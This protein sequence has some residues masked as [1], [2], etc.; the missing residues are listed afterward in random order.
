MFFAK[1]CYFYSPQSSSVI[2][3]DEGYNNTNI[4]KQLSPAKIRLHWLFVDEI[5]LS[6]HSN[7]TSTEELAHG[8]IYF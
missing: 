6:D 2:I 8:I 1:G 4:N 5:L 7:K 3:K